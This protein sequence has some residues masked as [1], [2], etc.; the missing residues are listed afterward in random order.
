MKKLMILILISGIAIFAYSQDPGTQQIVEDLLESTGEEMSDDTD[1]QEVLEDLEQLRQ[2]AL[3]VNTADLSE[4]QSLHF[5]SEFQIEN[6]I[7]FRKK[8]GTIY[9]LYEMASIDGFT[10]DIL[11]KI[12]PFVCFEAPERQF[13][14]RKS[15][16]DIFVRSNRTFTSG[17][18]DQ[19]K[20]EGSP[21]RYYLRFRHT[22]AKEEYGMVNEKDP[23][24]AFF[25]QSN[26]QGFD[27]TSAFLNFGIG[28]NGSRIYVGD[29]HVRFGQGLVAWQ[30]FAMGKS[31]ETTQVLRSNQGIKS[32]SSTDEN[33]FFRGLA[34]QFSSGNFTFYP[35][36]SQSRV[37]AHI[38]TINGNAYFGAFQTSGYHRTKSEIAG[39]NSL[40]Q[41]VGGVH[42][43]FSYRRWSFGLTS[44]YTRFTALLD[45]S[46]DPY[47]QFL[48]DGKESAVTGF[49]WKGSFNKIYFF[50]E[51]AVSQNSGKALLAGGMTK[52]AS[53]VEFSVVY[54]NFNKTYSSFFSNAFAESSRINDEHGLYVGIKVL[55]ASHWIIW[56]YSDFFKHQWIK[57]T[58]A[59]PANGA[60][61]FVQLL[62]NPSRKTGFYVRFFQEDKD[63]RLITDVARYNARQLINRL[64]FNYAH[65]LNEVFSLKSRVE[66]SFYSKQSSER[67]ILICQD[68]NFKP[69][70]KSFSMNGRLAYFNTDGYNSRL[71]AYEND[72]LYT[73][74]VPAMYGN[75][76]RSYFNFHQQFGSKFSFWL[77]LAETYQFAHGDGELR[78]DASSKTELK[79][80]IRYQF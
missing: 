9:S 20:Y 58:T 67:G 80:Q 47:N 30:G 31:A 73:F 33:L 45:R 79:M 25:G 60:E 50:G 39:E 49:D 43:N 21:E 3:N 69:K 16:N 71:Y 2:H 27:Y 24:E 35:F 17:G 57:Y 55:P 22:S 5:L 48:P 15:A 76:F 78:V 8:T 52:P 28:K 46:D 54:R 56:A 61:T 41:S 12:E 59:A 64:R 32:F 13:S 77:K 66:F 63:Q 65:N 62:Y 7:A 53:N 74:S 75:G 68:L 29:Y 10:P 44:V 70:E 11:Q 23:G 72:L 34:V 6:L 1:I 51:A 37:D 42:A 40:V 26:K 18:S 4:F 36:I 14:H 38:D 19:S